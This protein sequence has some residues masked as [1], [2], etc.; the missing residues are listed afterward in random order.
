MTC[1]E[2]R[3]LIQLYLDSELGARDTLEVQQHLAACSAC[4]ALLDWFFRQDELLRQ[5]ARTEAVGATDE[6]RA[7]ELILTKIHRQPLGF[8][9]RALRAA[10]AVLIAVAVA[11]LLLRSG[12]LTDNNSLVY[13]AIV[14]DHVDHCM[15]DKLAA[16]ETDRTKLNRLVAD[17]GGLKAVPD[18]LAFGYGIPRGKV[19]AV[20]GSPVLHLVYHDS[21]QQPLSLFLRPHGSDL[22]TDR[23]TVEVR[24]GSRVASVSAAGIDVFVVAV[25]VEDQTAEIVRFI[26][27]QL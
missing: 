7:R 21:L 15:A 17:Y 23:V 11:G 4:S 22:E 19:C 14:A 9:R 10:A 18:L 16:A 27:A 25:A 5:S 20:N 12:F 13:A 3:K 8:S 24:D 2:A 6:I 26:A 1:I